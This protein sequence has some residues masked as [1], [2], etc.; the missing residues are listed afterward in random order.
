[1]C[2]HLNIQ[3]DNTAH[4]MNLICNLQIVIVGIIL[5]PHTCLKNVSL[6]YSFRQIILASQ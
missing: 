6:T 2:K 1:M 4:S 3:R 5:T